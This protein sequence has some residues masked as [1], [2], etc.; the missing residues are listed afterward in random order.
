MVPVDVEKIR[1]DSQIYTLKPDDK[2]LEYH[3]AINEAAF[4]I[5]KENPLLIM[6]KNELQKLARKKVHESGFNYKKKGSRSK[7]FGNVSTAEEV[8]KREKMSQEIRNN[9][10][11]Q[12]VE[13]LKEVEV[14]MRYATLQREKCANVNNFSKAL[15]ISK[16]M[17]EL[18]NKKR[19]YQEEL[20]ILQKKE[21]LTKRV[22]K[23]LD[24]KGKATKTT[25]SNIQAFFLKKNTSVNSEDSPRTPRKESNNSCDTYQ[26][27]QDPSD[28]VQCSE[29][30]GTNQVNLASDTESD[31]TLLLQASRSPN[32][33][34]S[35]R[36]T[37]DA[38]GSDKGI[39]KENQ[40]TT[41]NSTLQDEARQAMEMDKSSVTTECPEEDF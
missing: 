21:C 32:S 30:S 4:S 18:C 1:K 9:R 16:E 41:P 20:A 28:S 6:N 24:K 40:E 26:S 5:A 36:D 8:P 22:K 38:V 31:G 35:H 11:S 29:K 25:E 2:L 27:K 33:P 39:S 23:C 10:I 14:Q 12:L 3:R 17:G 7:D 37:Q 19:K 34:R 15:D 13:D